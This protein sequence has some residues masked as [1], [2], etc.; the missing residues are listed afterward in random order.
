MSYFTA[1]TGQPNTVSVA[2]VH[3]DE[4]SVSE[5]DSVSVNETEAKSESNTKVSDSKKRTFKPR[6][7]N[8]N[9][10]NDEKKGGFKKKTYKKKKGSFK[11]NSPKKDDKFW[12]ELKLANSKFIK[13]CMVSKDELEQIE[14]NAR[15]D[16]SFEGYNI[17]FNV[18]QNEE[19]D[20]INLGYESN[21]KFKRSVMWKSNKF[22]DMVRDEYYD[23][24]PNLDLIFIGPTFKKGDLLLKLVPASRN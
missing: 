13:E 16:L 5:T 3:E 17:W 4:Q 6:K 7:F 14:V 24:A 23:L 10:S 22:R 12:E 18:G 11:K 20:L 19:K 21:N 1:L 9:N 15:Y 8:K 2:E